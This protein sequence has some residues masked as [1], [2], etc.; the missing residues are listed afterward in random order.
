M[1]ETLKRTAGYAT[2]AGDLVKLKRS[3]DETVRAN[4][5]QHLV[6]RLGRLRGLFLFKDFPA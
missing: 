2:L 6:E 1:F 5:R 3:R 4:A